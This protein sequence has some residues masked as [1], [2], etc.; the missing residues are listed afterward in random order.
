MSSR[1]GAN[2]PRSPLAWI[3]SMGGPLLAV[4]VSLLSAWEGCTETGMIWGE[5]DTPDDYD[6]A[7]AVDGL[8]GVIAVGD[9]D[10]RALVLGD[11]PDPGCYLPEHRAFLRWI[12]ADSEADLRAA[13]EAVL[14]DSAVE[15]E[16]CGVWVTDGPVILMD[17]VTPGSSPDTVHP[18]EGSP[19]RAPVPLSAGRWRVSAAHTRTDEGTQVSLVRLLPAGD[20]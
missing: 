7:C 10:G 17:S 12:A 5:T 4:P 2:E 19:E 15:W 1:I 14:A 20:L 8:A 16:E 13:A 18:G 11:G 9:G 3:E 6:R